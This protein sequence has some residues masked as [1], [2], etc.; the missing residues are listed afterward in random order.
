MPFDLLRDLAQDMEARGL[1]EPLEILPDGTIVCGHQRTRAATMLGWDEIDVW[2]NHGLSTQSERA[3]EQRLVE[4]NLTRRHLHRLDLVRCYQRLND[5][6]GEEHDGPLR[7]HQLGRIR[8]VVGVRL[9]MSGRTLDRYLRVLDAPREVQDAF[10]AGK[11]PL[12]Q[13]SRVAG[14][15]KETQE[16]LAADLRAGNDP[17]KAFR[18]LVEA[19]SSSPMD[20][21]MQSF[22]RS[23]QRNLEA[24][25]GH[26]GEVGELHSFDVSI[27]EDAKQLIDQ[28][29]NQ[30]R[31]ASVA[32]STEAQTSLAKGSW[33]GDPS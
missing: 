31:N 16:Q 30:H 4:D 22:V 13:A 24:L 32:S 2:I 5:M 1:K 33:M 28:L 9:G 20:L 15:S 27:L 25:E 3:V 10:K 21:S 19:R 26:V 12:V 17:R 6:A 14:L 23:L 8:D 29:L 11:L 7:S 18:R